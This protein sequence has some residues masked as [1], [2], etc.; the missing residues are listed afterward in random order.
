MTLIAV[1]RQ[2]HSFEYAANA[3]SSLC[4][5]GDMPKADLK[6]SKS[7]DALENHDELGGNSLWIRQICLMMTACAA[8]VAV[9]A[10][11]AAAAVD[12]DVEVALCLI[13]QLRGAVGVTH[14]MQ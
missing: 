4:V 12:N 1:Y 7:E 6:H 2:F 3:A 14:P 11:V 10:A 9:A 5:T 8:A 13:Q